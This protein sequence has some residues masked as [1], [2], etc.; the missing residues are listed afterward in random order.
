MGANRPTVGARRATWPGGASWNRAAS[1]AASVEAVPTGFS[2]DGGAEGVVG[3]VTTGDGSV[4]APGPTIGAGVSRIG[5][6]LQACNSPIAENTTPNLTLCSS[7]DGRWQTE[8]VRK[9]MWLIFLEAG[10][11]LALLLGIVYWTM[12]GKK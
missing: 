6:K 3:A 12:R 8:T 1:V 10:I 5:V 4:D 9:D 2:A 7:L 11:A